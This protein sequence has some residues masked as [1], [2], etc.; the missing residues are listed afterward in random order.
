MIENIDNKII[1]IN[2]QTFCITKDGRFRKN[3]KSQ[4]RKKLTNKIGICSKCHK[5]K[6]L[7]IHH[8]PPL[9]EDINGK[10]IKLCKECHRLI[11]NDGYL[12]LPF[13]IK[14]KYKKRNYFDEKFIYC[15]RCG[16]R[17]EVN[18]INKDEYILVNNY[19]HKDLMKENP[20][21]LYHTKKILKW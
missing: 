7:T 5:K 1:K 17:R 20:D 9:R 4:I 14:C 19:S 2:N 15:K 21:E 10:E 12:G 11:H 13:I 3:W 6:H 18:E 16:L 8:D